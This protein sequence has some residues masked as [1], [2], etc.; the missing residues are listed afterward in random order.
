MMKRNENNLFLPLFSALMGAAAMLL[1]CGL[2]LL[3][4][5]SKGLLITGH[6]LSLLTWALTAAAVA[7]IAVTVRKRDGSQ[8]YAD[9][10]APSATA[11]IGAI[12]LAGGI[13]ITI[14]G[15]WPAVT[16][17][18]RIRDCLGLGAVG[19]LIWVSLRRFQGKQPC[20]LCHGLVCIYLIV[21]AI[22]HYRPWC[23]RPQLQTVF[24][25]VAGIL[26]LCL[27]AYY[28]TAFDA[29]MGSRRA[30]LFTGLTAGFFCLAALADG[31]DLAL[32]AGGAVWALTN[33]CHVAP[34]TKDDSH[35]PA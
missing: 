11:A 23:S 17:L 20:F 29:D 34:V 35:E 25:S 7:V 31:A 16:R 14:I 8:Q 15:S 6:P 30:Q 33:L 27:F 2:Y 18:E 12:V 24:F 10:F 4:T 1:R 9:N 28:Q 22:S 5:D 13:A 3:G 19:A 21:Y 32:F 26:L